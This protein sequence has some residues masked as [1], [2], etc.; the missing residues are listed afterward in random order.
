MWLFHWLLHQHHLHGP[1]AQM[2]PLA[3]FP[4]LMSS[5]YTPHTMR[6]K[7]ENEK[8]DVYNNSNFNKA[9]YSC[10]KICFG[11]S[12][13]KRSTEIHYCLHLV[14]LVSNATSS[15]ACEQNLWGPLYSQSKTKPNNFQF[16]G[17]LKQHGPTLY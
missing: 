3:Y 14:I 7:T 16:N 9:I 6:G 12:D 8:E 5:L 17:K 13:H 15:K 2:F 1:A 4:E 11:W 10:I